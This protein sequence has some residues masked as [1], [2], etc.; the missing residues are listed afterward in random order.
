MLR[1]AGR[2]CRWLAAA[3]TSRWRIHGARGGARRRSWPSGRLGPSTGTH[4]RRLLT[5]VASRHH[6]RGERRRTPASR[7]PRGHGRRGG[8]VDADALRPAVLVS[9]APAEVDVK[10][11]VFQEIL[12]DRERLNLAGAAADRPEFDVTEETLGRVL[13]RVARP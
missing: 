8:G 11:S 13:L 10:P 3:W 1:H 9:I 12:G 4:C 2:C 6:P 7:C 5:A